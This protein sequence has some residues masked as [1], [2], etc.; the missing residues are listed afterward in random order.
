M[1]HPPEVTPTQRRIRRSPAIIGAIA[2]AISGLL[3]APICWILKDGLLGAYPSYGLGA[4]SHFFWSLLWGLWPVATLV[5][6]LIGSRSRMVRYICLGLLGI[7]GLIFMIPLV[8]AKAYIDYMDSP[9][10]NGSSIT[11]WQQGTG[12]IYHW[13]ADT[14]AREDDKIW[15][16]WEIAHN[17]THC[18]RSR[19]GCVERPVAQC[20]L[21]H[22]TIRWDETSVE[23]TTRAGTFT[24]P[25][26]EQDSLLLDYLYGKARQVKVNMR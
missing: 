10:R 5:L 11:L 4:V 9:F 6:L 8:Y 17:S 16:D 1:I 18:W 20:E 25:R 14:D 2:T 23:I 19:Q 12:R 3:S 24:R 22:A 13:S 7:C 26:N 15:Q 21:H